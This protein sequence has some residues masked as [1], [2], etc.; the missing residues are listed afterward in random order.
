MKRNCGETDDP[1]KNFDQVKP[2]WCK[3]SLKKNES[4]DGKTVIYYANFGSACGCQET[5][6][7]KVKLAKGDD[8]DLAARQTSAAQKVLDKVSLYSPP[9]FDVGAVLVT[10][11]LC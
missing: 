6:T 2:R 10:R 1:Y 9:I 3:D 7:T 5:Q 8:N 4:R 11:Q